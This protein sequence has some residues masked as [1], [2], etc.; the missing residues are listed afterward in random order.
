[1]H[2]GY[3]RISRCLHMACPMAYDPL[4]PAVHYPIDIE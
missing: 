3:R 1:M 2:P 4:V